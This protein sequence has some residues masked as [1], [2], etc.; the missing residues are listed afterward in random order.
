MILKVLLCAPAVFSV[1]LWFVFLND[2][3]TTRG[4]E[5]TTGAQR[6]PVIGHYFMIPEV[7]LEPRREDNFRHRVETTD[8]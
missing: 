6:K 4:T 8:R 2:L 3:M 1:S 7:V 5:N